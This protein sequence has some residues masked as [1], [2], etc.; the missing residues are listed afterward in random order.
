MFRFKPIKQ[1]RVYT[2]IIEQIKQMLVRGELKPGDRL[3]SERELAEQV[4]VSRASVREAFSALDLLGIL[5]SK[6][7]EGTFIRQQPDAA[8]IEPLALVFMLYKDSN[9]EVLEFRTMLEVEGVALAAERALPADIE[10]LEKHL[11][12][13]QSEILSNKLGAVPDAQFHIT[14]AEITGNR[15]LVYM[16]NTISDLLVETMRY[17]R[18]KLFMRPGNSEKLFAQHTEIYQA[19][20]ASDPEV[21][22]QAMR[23]HLKFVREEI[24]PYEK[25][26]RS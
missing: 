21:A 18:E 11:V 14:I 8:V 20:A 2:E 7:G 19:I 6:T 12:D 15:A 16:M 13:M 1:K 3:T 25:N 26:P 24:S 23:C 10:R 9:L 17:S 4:H 5:E 22:R